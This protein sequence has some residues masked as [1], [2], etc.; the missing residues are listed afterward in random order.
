MTDEPPKKKALVEFTKN[1]QL[2]VEDLDG[3][4]RVA[5]VYAANLPGTKLEELILRIIKGRE[6]GLNVGMSIENIAVIRGRPCLWGDGIGAVA[7][8]H[9]RFS[10]MQKRWFKGKEELQ[11]PATNPR[12]LPD[13]YRCV[14]EVYTKSPETGEEHPQPAVDSF[15][16]GE[17][18][19]AGLWG[20]KGP[21]TEHFN[22]MLWRRA[23][24][25]AVQTAVPSA[26]GG[27]LLDDEVPREPEYTVLG[28]TRA[29]REAQERQHVET[30]TE[31]D[32]GRSVGLDPGAPS[33]A[34]LRAD[35][36]D[37]GDAGER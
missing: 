37:P 27:L 8:R 30:G 21:W 24:K 3:A 16:V 4:Q 10:R 36:G 13:D 7:E 5:A 35:G 31:H 11:F 25:R 32:P 12:D 26:L 23:L 34:T 22:V 29:I 28:A 2:Y 1:G 33:G 6:L 17:A 18:K 9:P 14:V 20:N 15:S 19:A